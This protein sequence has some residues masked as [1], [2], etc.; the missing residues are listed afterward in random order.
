[1][2]DPE[3][4]RDIAITDGERM[5]VSSVVAATVVAVSVVGPLLGLMSFSF[6]ATMTVSDADICSGFD[7]D[8]GDS[9]G[10]YGWFWGGC[11]HVG[12]GDSR[13]GLFWKRDW[14]WKW[15]RW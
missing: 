4:R 3:G 12:G 9:C 6:V 15:S 13:D 5:T 10:G 8:G 11:C 2:E 7:G 14:Y 1:M